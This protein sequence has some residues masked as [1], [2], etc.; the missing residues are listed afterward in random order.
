MQYCR[1][2]PDLPQ[3]EFMNLLSLPLIKWMVRFLDDRRR[4]TSEGGD[5]NACKHMNAF[6]LIELLTVIAIIAVGASVTLAALPSLTKSNQF[7]GNLQVFSDL[8]EQAR[9]I[10]TSQNSYVW[11]GLAEKDDDLLVVARLGLSGDKGDFTS[12]ARLMNRPRTLRG[13]KFSDL[14]ANSR[15]SSFE[16][17]ADSWSSDWAFTEKVKGTD[18]QFQRVI[19]FSPSG[20]VAV[21][22]AEMKNWIALAFAPT[23]SS[24]ANKADLFIS[25]MTAHV[26]IE[27]P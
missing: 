6:S 2:N 13:M 21:K 26:E 7:S 15:D 9:T 17:S 27:R 11:L 16:L 20:E 22:N 8:V 25:A 3:L 10:S 1:C 19:R 14:L 4:E 12:M 24:E 18:V 23:S 5:R